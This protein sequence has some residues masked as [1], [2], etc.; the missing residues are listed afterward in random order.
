[1]QADFEKKSASDFQSVKEFNEYLEKAQD[2]TK[3]TAN[4][5]ELINPEG[6][7]VTYRALKKVEK[8]IKR[9]NKIKEEAFSKLKDKPHMEQGRKTGLTIE[10]AA[11]RTVGFADPKF[12][13]FEKLDFNPKDYTSDY[14][15][16]KEL[17]KLK[18]RYKGDFI[19]D[20]DELYWKNYL[21]S[22]KT[23]FNLSGNP[24]E[25]HLPD[26]I[27]EIHDK[28]LEMGIEKFMELY[29]QGKVPNIPFIYGKGKKDTVMMELQAAFRTGEYA[30]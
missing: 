26:E 19:G 17:E 21:Q 18:D 12:K 3:R 23:R 25:Y 16:E 24:M 7:K 9:I 14:E 8:E 6:G 10:Q 30:E 2:F 28:V 13:H 4:R 11:G 27:W 1:M 22:L 20:R 5:F 15:A 29:Y